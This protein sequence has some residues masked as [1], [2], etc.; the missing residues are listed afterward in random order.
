MRSIRNDENWSDLQSGADDSSGLMMK[1][2]IE[3]VR[4][5]ETC[6]V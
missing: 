3:G 1:V 4:Y 2:A 5:N 6:A